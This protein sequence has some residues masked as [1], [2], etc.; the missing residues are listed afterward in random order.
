M[1]EGRIIRSI[2]NKKPLREQG[3]LRGNTRGYIT[4]KQGETVMLF[5]G[6]YTTM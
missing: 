4:V 2:R 1:K 5:K 3:N 6:Y